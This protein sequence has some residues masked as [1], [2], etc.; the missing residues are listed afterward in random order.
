MDTESDIELV[1]VE[2]KLKNQEN[3]KIGSFHRPPWAN[4][5]C[6]EVLAQTLH[7]INPKNSGSIWLGG[8]FLPHINWPDQQPLPS[9]PN[10]KLSEMLID[11]ANNHS[12]IQVV[13]HPTRKENILDPFFTTNPSLVN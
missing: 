13:E 2:L 4:D 10:T 5:S 1:F 3:I 9:N 8:D 7:Q 12:L 11:A 6:M